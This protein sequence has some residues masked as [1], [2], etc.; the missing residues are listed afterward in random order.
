MKNLLNRL[1]SRPSSDLAEFDAKLWE[2]RKQRAGAQGH[3]PVSVLT[4]PDRDQLLFQTT[5]HMI[6]EVVEAQRLLNRR[7]WRPQVSPLIDSE[8]M[9]EFLE[10]LADVM[11]MADCT[12]YYAGATWADLRAAMLAKIEKNASRL[13]NLHAETKSA[14]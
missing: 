12:L 9:A 13:D 5:S 3:Y 11:L 7:S 4:V 2:A 1:L 8:V 10:E 14:T 6:E